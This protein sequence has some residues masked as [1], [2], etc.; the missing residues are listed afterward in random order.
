MRD[1]Q[2]LIAHKPRLGRNQTQNDLQA[3]TLNSDSAPTNV[4]NFASRKSLS[5]YQTQT[6]GTQ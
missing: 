1:A 6:Q 5:L 4:G 2:R 3:M